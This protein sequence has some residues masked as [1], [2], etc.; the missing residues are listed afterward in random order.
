M[1]PAPASRAVPRAT[2]VVRRS[3]SRRASLPLRRTWAVEP[4][5]LR[6]PD[7][8]DEAAAELRERL[9]ALHRQPH[10]RGGSGPARE[11]RWPAPA[12]VAGSTRTGSRRVAGGADA[13][14]VA[15]PWSWL[16]VSRQLSGRCRRCS[17][18]RRRCR[19]GRRGRPGPSRPD[20]G[21]PASGGCRSRRSGRPDPCRRWRR[22]RRSPV[23]VAV[24]LPRIRDRAAV[25]RAI[26]DRVVVVVEV[27]L[28]PRPSSS[29][30]VWSG[31]GW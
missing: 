19:R 15:S 2:V 7:R 20:R 4:A 25:V 14:A 10:G 22:R 1:L 23:A 12:A 5:C 27:A 8:R 6:A 26:E 28:V 18:H 30:S 17:R 31:C 16:G 3:F 11:E 29:L 21:S 13:V 24:L 9:P